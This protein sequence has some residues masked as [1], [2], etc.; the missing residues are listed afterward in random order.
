MKAT[1]SEFA[2][3]LRILCAVAILCVGFAHKPTVVGSQIPASDIAAYTLPDGTI[4]ILCLPGQSDPD[5][6]HKHASSDGCEACRITSS[7]LLP[8]PADSIG[9]R[10]AVK[11]SEQLPPRREAF[12]ARWLRAHA[13]PRAPPTHMILM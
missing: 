8:M 4:P 3:V 1:A 10:L 6:Q 5:K 2:R 13:S 11:A 12:V 7:V 9:Q